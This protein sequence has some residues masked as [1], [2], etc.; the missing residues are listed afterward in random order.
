[1]RS[2]R[3]P[4]MLGR[5]TGHA[6]SALSSW[7]LRRGKQRGGRRSHGVK[8]GDDPH[9]VPFRHGLGSGWTRPSWAKPGS[10][11]K[12]EGHN[13]LKKKETSQKRKR[14]KAKKEKAIK[15]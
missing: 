2:P 15:Y 1:M 3:C 8:V 12:E 4:Y 13:P 7:P 5:S 14:R 9:R 10:G 6:G 11:E